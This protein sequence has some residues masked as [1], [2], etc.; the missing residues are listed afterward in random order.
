VELP[1]TLKMMNVEL[2]EVR[3]EAMEQ[4]ERTMADVKIFTDGPMMN[5]RV[6]AAAVLIREGTEDRTLKVY[7]DPDTEHE[8]YGAEVIGL[9]LGLHL[10][11]SERFV[12]SAA[13]FNRSQD[14]KGWTETRRRTWR[15]KTRERMG[16]VRL[17][18]YRNI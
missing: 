13:F 6:G 2:A 8:V 15:R 5:G 16:V 9:Q 3:E 12:S 18:T 4:E 10:L 11:E 7:L 14:I 1:I 17:K